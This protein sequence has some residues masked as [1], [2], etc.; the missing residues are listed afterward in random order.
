MDPVLAAPS[1]V[2][3]LII[4]WNLGTPSYWRDETATLDAETRSIPALSHML[5]DVDA[6]HGAYYLLMWPIV[7]TF[8]TSE[9]VLRLP[10]LLA[11]TVAAAG[12]AALGRRLHSPRAGL[13]AGL[14]FAVLPQVSRYGQEARCYAL[15]LACAVLASYLLVRATDEPS[16]GR[17]TGYACAIA[18]LGLLNLF[19]L[20]LLVGHTIFL[21]ARHRTLLRHWL[22][23]ATLACLPVLPV[24]VMAWQQRN[25]LAWLTEPDATAPGNLAAWLAGSSAAVVIL[26]VL[27][28]LGLRQRTGRTAAWLAL[29]WLLAPPLLLL[30]AAELAMPVYVQR[31]VAYCLPA[32]ALPVG[33]GLATITVLPRV[34][35]LLLV[36]GL[37]LPTQLAQRQVDGH[38]DDIRPAADIISAHE[39][40][41]DGVLYYCPSCRATD[42][43][44]DFSFGYP[45]A[46]GPLDDLA[47]AQSPAASGTLTGIDTDRPTLI[48]RLDGINRVWL[49]ETGGNA[50]PAPLAD[51]GLHLA[52]LFPAGNVLVALYQR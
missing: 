24:I 29:P 26:T 51:S 16:R 11:M 20:L 30:A 21:L 19:G 45:A 3:V 38:G 33:V 17:L 52:A 28:G 2:T 18:A 13:F 12:V 50:V 6:V 48:R 32:L 41:G 42:M 46:F 4:A 39:Q 35:A 8:G 1:I 22:A 23:A 10:S 40:P 7:H 9:I 47:L 15:V 44:R 27:I 31:Y 36:A 5:T 14:T 49:V 43:P 34:L 37:G 25:Q